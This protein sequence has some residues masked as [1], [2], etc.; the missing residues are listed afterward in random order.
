MAGEEEKLRETCSYHFLSRIV[1]VASRGE[2]PSVVWVLVGDNTAEGETDSPRIEVLPPM[3]ALQSRC[4]AAPA[5]A[6]PERLTWMTCQGTTVYWLRTQF[7]CL[8]PALQ[9]AFHVLQSCTVIVAVIE[10]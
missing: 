10:W 8:N 1:L 7:F 9:V 4:L 6:Y 3:T 5:D 2:A